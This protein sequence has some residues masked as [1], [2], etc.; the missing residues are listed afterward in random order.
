[1]PYLKEFY[2]IEGGL[3]TARGDPP[4]VGL[5]HCCVYSV[6]STIPHR[7]YT[8]HSFPFVF[9]VFSLGIGTVLFAFQLNFGQKRSLILTWV[10]Q[11]E[12]FGCVC[13]YKREFTNA[14][15]WC[16]KIFSSLNL[17]APAVFL[18]ERDLLSRS[19]VCKYANGSCFSSYSLKH[20]FHVLKSLFS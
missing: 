13:H 10:H 2:P 11:R 14:K 1:M 8:V 20:T 19:S 9:T 18:F 15:Q 16:V 17:C 4:F 7:T 12:K 5:G 6:F 3:D